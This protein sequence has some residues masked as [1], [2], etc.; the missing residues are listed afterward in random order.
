MANG[1]QLPLLSQ[2]VREAAE[3]RAK[4]GEAAGVR[5]QPEQATPKADERRAP[6]PK[7]KP[8]V[9]LVRVKLAAKSGAHAQQAGSGAELDPG[10]KRTRV[11]GQDA[12]KEGANGN[13]GLGGLLGDYGSDADD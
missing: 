1:R 12:E 2:A 3:R 5:P 4:S 6:A 9:P 13:G 10:E 7:R 8:A 11:A